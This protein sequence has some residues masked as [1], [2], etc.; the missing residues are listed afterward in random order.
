MYLSVFVVFLA[1]YVVGALRHDL[2]EVSSL[3]DLVELIHDLKMLGVLSIDTLITGTWSAALLTPLSVA[4]DYLHGSLPLKFGQTY[5]DLAF[6]VVPGFVADWV[7]YARPIDSFKGPAWEMTYG[8]GGTHAV[9]VPFTDFR[10][11]G[12]YVVMGLFSFA[13]TRIE[14]YA[15][16]RPSVANLSLLGVIAMAI[17]HWL[18]YGEKNIINA[19]VIWAVLAVAYRIRLTKRWTSHTAGSAQSRLHST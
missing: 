18:W 3:A 6:S 16:T 11:L 7:G 10:M 1:A 12:V 9:V 19:L 8:L 2:T 17:P 15:I 14:R 4:G 5:I 13:I